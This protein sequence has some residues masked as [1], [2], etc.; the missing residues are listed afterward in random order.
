LALTLVAENRDDEAEQA[1]NQQ[2]LEKLTPLPP[3]VRERSAFLAGRPITLPVVMPYSTWSD[4][5]RHIEPSAVE[6]PSWGG[7]MV[8]YRWMLRKPA[9]DL[10]K[11][12]GLDVDPA[13]EPADEPFPRVMIDSAWVQ[14]ADNQRS[15][16]EGFSEQLTEHQSL[17][18]FYAKR[19]P[20]SEGIGRPIVAVATLQKKGTVDEYPYKGGVAG[21]R[22]RSM[23]WERPFQ[24]SLRRTEKGFEGGVVLPYQQLHEFTLSK[25]DLDPTEYL[26]FPPPETAHE[27]LYGS[28]HVSHGSAISALQAIRNSVEKFSTLFEGR[29][30]DA[31]RWIDEKI[32]EIWQLRGP[33]PGLGSA[34]T[35]IEPSGFKG[36]LFAHALEGMLPD[37]S[38]PWPVINEIFDGKRPAPFAGPPLTGL[39]RKRF[40][41]IRYKEPEKFALLQMLSRFELTKDQAVAAYEASDPMRIV[42]NPYVLFEE[43]RFWESPVPLGVIDHGLFGGG[44]IKGAWPLPEE[45]EVRI[46]ED[47]DAYRLRAVT[48]QLLEQA[49][50]AGD[51][52]QSG[53]RL[54]EAVDALA[55]TPG[56]PIDDDAL[57][58]LEDEFYPIVQVQKIGDEHFAQLERYADAGELIR[59]H[60]KARLEVKLEK[61]RVHWQTEL[62][63]ELL[64]PAN[65][66]DVLEIE[67]RKEKAKALEVLADNRLAVLTGP[68]GSGKTT[69]LRALLNQPDVV[70]QNIELLAPTGKARVRLGQ[71]TRMQSR[72]R[73][74]AQF[75]LQTERWDP[76]T[77]AYSFAQ[78][79]GT[80][81]VSTCVVD[82]ASMLT[83]DQLAALLSALPKTTR[84][85]LVGDPRQ[86]PPIGAGRPFVDLISHLTKECGGSQ[87]A[88]LQ[89]S[90]RQN[91]AG[92]Q[93]NASSLA[94]VQLAELFSGRDPG[95]AEGEALNTVRDDT[96]LHFIEWDAPTN[97]RDSIR[98]VLLKELATGRQAL[99]AAVDASLGALPDEN[100]PFRLG[101]GPCADRWQI[102]TPHRD[103]PN[104]SAELNRL[105]KRVARARWLNVARGAVPGSRIVDARGP[106]QIT[107]GDKV[108]CLRNH[109]RYSWSPGRNSTEEHYLANGEVGVVVGGTGAHTTYTNVEFSTQPMES[110]GFKRKDFGDHGAP[111]LELGYAV[112]IHKAQ[113]SEFDAVILV[114]PANSRLLSRELLYTALT[115]QQSRIWILH[116]G[117]F[118]SF[119]L[120][121]SAFYS[122]TAR[123]VT[124]LFAEPQ[125]RQIGRPP[126]APVSERPRFLE[127]NLIHAT[128]RGDLVRSKNEVIIA[129]ILQDLEDKQ[130]IQYSV[131]KPLLL[132]KERWPDFTIETDTDT[133]YWEHCGMLDDPNYLARWEEKKAAYLKKG[134]SEW[135]AENPNGR[136]IVTDDGKE[137]GINSGALRSLA[138]SLW[139]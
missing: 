50:A 135:S 120:L 112:T 105:V 11:D 24:H 89:I 43:S 79:G 129:D 61:S 55:L 85:I 91:P 9:W 99:E 23:V 7:I 125:M 82:E 33:A 84:L 88:E 46:D 72:A 16:L 94:D 17:V 137:K 96:R 54:A 48:V 78:V 38:N 22:I 131:E 20:L 47:D 86:L 138:E 10:A 35:C 117:P 115:R 95:P 67:A 92:E 83:E 58:L 68:A 134:I 34:L 14:D 80:A 121:R 51:T 57:E 73:T 66:D 31:I 75:L 52:L 36:T 118:S 109:K 62:D 110:F 93:L 87:V 53:K 128:R 70:G 139:S 25:P 13:R 116:Q 39:L 49:A 100:T 71:Q 111:L 114:L 133:W 107:Y 64:G 113:G 30:D 42:K 3:C 104:G 5:H 119:T 108:I 90:R 60:V 32:N 4:D 8:P 45:T 97:L 74:L 15:L 77:N 19:T 27:F 18:F 132:D 69:L 122:E 41:K 101:A 2:N 37:D 136:L 127:K 98:E 1:N 59:R 40:E 123:R 29:W 124:N 76:K 28:E 63:K 26:A 65:A 21:G 102:L 44:P 130:L 56:A 103:L 106:D 12:Y 126:A 6:L 81:N